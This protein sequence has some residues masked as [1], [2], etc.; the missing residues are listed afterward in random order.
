MTLSARANLATSGRGVRRRSG[1][2]RA[3]WRGPGL[4]L[5]R[6][7]APILLAVVVFAQAA[8]ASDTTAATSTTPGVTEAPVPPP[9]RPPE[10]PP[11]LLQPVPASGK[12]RLA[13]VIGGN[14][15]SCTYPGDRMTR[16]LQKAGTFEKDNEGFTFG[17]HF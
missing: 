13:M 14:R 12:G 9:V 7:V 4:V 1:S 17:D 2:T 11:Q 10:I 16:P 5:T 15:R 8:R 3:S 6:G